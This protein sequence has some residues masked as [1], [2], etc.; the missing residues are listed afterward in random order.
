MLYLNQAGTSWP[1]PPAVAAAIA[2]AHAATPDT[3]A[4][5]L[6]ADHAIVC[7]AFGVRDPS[8]MLLAPNATS[9]LAVGICDHP[10]EAGDRVIVS[11]LEH[12]AIARPVQQLVSNHVERV[13]VPRS[14]R[15]SVVLPELEAELR[16]GRVRLVAMTAAC[17]VTG[18]L[19][20][21]ERV[22]SLAHQYGALCLIDAAQIAGW[23]PLDVERLGVDLLAFAGHKGPQGPIGIGGLYVAANV[24]MTSPRA[25]CEIPSV[26]GE[27]RGAP[28]PGYC[29]VGSLDR[30][31]LAGLAAGFGWLATPERSGRLAVARSSIAQLEEKLSDRPELTIH[32]RHT[33]NAGMPTLAVTVE[34]RSPAELAGALAVRGVIASGGLQCAPVAHETLG[35]HPDGVL[36]LSV[37]PTN[38]PGDASIAGDALI[39]CLDS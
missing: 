26:G 3:W 38:G 1:K 24:T 20:P 18:E 22:I 8:R 28:M 4:N 9:A 16:R 12:H 27:A 30:A 11:G 15:E 31:A 36:R 2:Q 35:T 23:L 39:D 29:D 5:R 17:N 34:D 33:S 25:S 32:G 21:F 19:L 13:V 14:S 10:W 6:E 37:G 7:R